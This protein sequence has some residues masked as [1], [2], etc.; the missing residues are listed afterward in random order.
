MRCGT[1]RPVPAT[2]G[3]VCGREMLGRVNRGMRRHASGASSSD[4]GSSE[5]QACSIHHARNRQ[6]AL[7]PRRCRTH[8]GQVAAPRCIDVAQSSGGGCMRLS[9]AGSLQQQGQEGRWRSAAW[10]GVTQSEMGRKPPAGTQAGSTHHPPINHPTIA[11]LCAGG[12]CLRHTRCVAQYGATQGGE[13]IRGDVGCGRAAGSGGNQAGEGGCGGGAALG[14]RGLGVGEASH[15][16]S[17]GGQQGGE[18]LQGM[19]VTRLVGAELNGAEAAL[20][21]FVGAGPHWLQVC[22]ALANAPTESEV[23][24]GPEAVPWVRP[25]ARLPAAAPCTAPRVDTVPSVAAPVAC[26]V[27]SSV[28]A[29]RAGGWSAVAVM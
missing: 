26:A 27:P 15:G 2:R 9:V 10:V 16:G 21:A 13:G 11:Y 29:G 1:A 23:A 7:G 14:G 22:R 20:G 3:S 19:E 5:R 18:G 4:R 24:A 6:P 25:E 12:P 28:P 8:L 17:V